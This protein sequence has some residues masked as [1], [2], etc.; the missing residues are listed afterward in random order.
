M[1]HSTPVNGI[2]VHYLEAGDGSGLEAVYAG[3]AGQLGCP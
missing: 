2:D 1:Q 3:I